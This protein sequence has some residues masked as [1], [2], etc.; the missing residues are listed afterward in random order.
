MKSGLFEICC[1]K[2]DTQRPQ[3]NILLFRR[4]LALQTWPPRSP[5]NQN[6]GQQRPCPR[7]RSQCQRWHSEVCLKKTQTPF[8]PSES[9]AFQHLD[10]V[11]SDL[12]GPM[13]SVSFSGCLYFLTFLDDYSVKLGL[14]SQNKRP[15][16]WDFQSI[17]VSSRNWERKKNKSFEDRRRRWVQLKSFQQLL[18]NFRNSTTKVEYTPQQN[19]WAERLNRSLIEKSRTL[20]LTSKVSGLRLFP[21]VVTWETELFTLQLRSQTICFTSQSLGMCSAFQNFEEG[22]QVFTTN[23]TWSSPW[24]LRNLKIL[25][26]SWPFNSKDRHF[27]IRY[28]WGRTVPTLFVRNFSFFWHHLLSF[29]HTTSTLTSSPTRTSRKLGT[30]WTSRKYPRPRT[31]NR[32]WKWEHGLSCSSG[33]TC[34]PQPTS[35]SHTTSSTYSE[36]NKSDQASK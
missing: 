30:L 3:N 32:K 23:Q 11:H 35:N 14:L 9:P 7:P 27:K 33:T 13:K 6:N 1:Q 2:T 15:S 18:P 17:Q 34:S 36:K 4:T 28:F 26:N 20:L 16:L 19:C 12:C 24:L 10:L 8:Q 22:N 25:S 31:R 29:S 21:Q 5:S